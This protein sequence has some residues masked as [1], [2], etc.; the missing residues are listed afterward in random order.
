MSAPHETDESR[1]SLVMLAF[2]PAVWT[3][4]LIFS[5]GTAAVW[6]EKYAAAGGSL[7][8]ARVAIAIYTLIALTAIGAAAWYGFRRHTFGATTVPHDFD[9][10]E[11]RHSFLGFATLLLALLSFVATVYVA[12]VIIFIRTC[13]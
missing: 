6:C 2:G 4:H 11:S 5:Y 13:Q 10:R 1:Q 3:V 8:G 12:L 7:G 9:S